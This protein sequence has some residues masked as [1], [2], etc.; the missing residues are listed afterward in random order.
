MRYYYRYLVS[1]RRGGR[2]KRD[3][4]VNSEHNTDSEPLQ[5]LMGRNH[6]PGVSAHKNVYLQ[7]FSFVG[8]LSLIQEKKEIITTVTKL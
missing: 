8:I 2:R 1:R 7:I 3:L 6:N 4:Y 5:L